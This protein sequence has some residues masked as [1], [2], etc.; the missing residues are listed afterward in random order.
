MTS[1]MGKKHENNITRRKNTPASIREKK[2][3]KKTW[4]TLCAI[5]RK[6]RLENDHGV[7]ILTVEHFAFLSRAFQGRGAGRPLDLKRFRS[8]IHPTKT[9][10][11]R[12]TDGFIIKVEP[13]ACYSS[14]HTLSQAK[15]LSMFVPSVSRARARSKSTRYRHR[16]GDSCKTRKQAGVWSMVGS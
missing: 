4:C 10:S 14:D 9:S 8:S 3:K 13:N 1:S 11:P 7:T 16:P 2:K 5:A 6:S 12:V 15:T